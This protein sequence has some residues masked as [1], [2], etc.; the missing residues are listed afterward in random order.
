[1][2]TPSGEKLALDG[3]QPVRTGPFPRRTPFGDREIE[4]VT[5]AI[6]SQNLFGP[7]GRMVSEFER[8]FAAL[9]GLQH[10]AAS[11]SGTAA[12]HVAV[13]TINPDPGDEIITAPITDLG[14]VVPIL[15]QTAVP[16]FAD[17]DGTYTMDPED[18]E[19]KITR[20]TKAI[21]VVHLFGNPC[22]M[23]AMLDISK[24]HGIPLIEDCS[25]AHLTAYR[26]R[27]VGTMGDLGAFSLQQSKHLTTGDGGMTV[28]R[29]GEWAERMRLFVDKA[30]TR[31]PGWGPRTYL[32][33]SP[34]YR[35]TELQGAVGIAQCERV[36]GVVR[37][38]NELGSLLSRLIEG[39]RG[40]HAP[41]V[42]PGGVHTYWSYPLRVTRWKPETFAK[43]LQAEG[44][45][46]SGGYIGKPI[47]LC[48]DAL[49]RW[50]TFGR[51]GFPFTSPYVDGRRVYDESLCPRAQEALDHMV[52]LP[53]HES[54]ADEDVKDMA[55]A[56]QKVSAIL[57]DS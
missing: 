9:Y 50:E 43:A 48:A 1:M 38:R 29:R 41:P 16:V 37:R 53:V 28:T 7:S 23:D 26:G 5:E 4:L 13:G 8:R 10:A 40:V 46:A 35:M 36:Q 17:V 42:T 32:F 22:D 12:I 57:P 52:N 34:N 18:V 15:Y 54:L 21:L 39:I 49:C 51:S 19:R 14:S 3:G 56:V 6:R 11:S 44:V 2:N 47:F 25:Q 45:P 20:R 33:L 30:W 31:K 24:R 27:L 55:R